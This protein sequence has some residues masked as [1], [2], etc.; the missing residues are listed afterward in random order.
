MEG[1]FDVQG[2]PYVL[3]YPFGLDVGIRVCIHGRSGRWA[4]GGEEEGKKKCDR[5][6]LAE[7]PGACPKKI[8]TQ[9]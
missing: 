2:I 3:A 6:P 4:A 9:R 7:A 1:L 5:H 8:P